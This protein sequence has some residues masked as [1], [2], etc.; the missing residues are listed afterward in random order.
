MQ[1]CVG[2]LPLLFLPPKKKQQR[3]FTLL[4][5]DHL[6]CVYIHWYHI[7]YSHTSNRSETIRGGREP[8]I[9]CTLNV[10]GKTHGRTIKVQLM[11]IF[12][13]FLAFSFLYRSPGKVKYIER[14]WFV[15]HMQ[16]ILVTTRIRSISMQFQ[17]GHIRIRR[18][19]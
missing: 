10:R 6:K 19:E 12:F 8:N 4:L 5:A 2:L 18:I 1:Y 7:V 14:P 17:H 15:E 13:L 3:C 16:H 9:V 11:Q